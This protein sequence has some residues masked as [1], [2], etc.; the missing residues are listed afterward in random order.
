MGEP[1]RRYG[2]SVAASLCP[3]AWNM[4]NSNVAYS[5]T[6]RLGTPLGR[7]VIVVLMVMMP[8]TV[9]NMTQIFQ[10]MIFP[11]VIH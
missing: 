2:A 1:Q 3:L 4:Q 11:K 8:R 10:V 9:N 5:D 6:L 7:L